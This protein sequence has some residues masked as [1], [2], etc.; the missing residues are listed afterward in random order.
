MLKNYLHVNRAP[1]N[2]PFF[3]EFFYK[4]ANQHGNSLATHIM[5]HCGCITEFLV[6]GV[7]S[8]AGR[9]Q[10]QEQTF[11]DSC[12]SIALIHVWNNGTYQPPLANTNDV[13]LRLL[14]SDLGVSL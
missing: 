3:T 5:G 7:L 1:H 2:I 11:S 9:R 14:S 10:S 4:D 12:H 13:S 8:D 6:A